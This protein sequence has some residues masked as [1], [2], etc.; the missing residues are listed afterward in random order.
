MFKSIGCGGLIGIANIVPGISG[1][2]LAVITNQYQRIIKNIDAITMIQLKNVEWGYL[3]C[4]A[5]G[6]IG[7][8]Y[9]F[10][11]PLDYALSHFNNYTLIMIIGLILGSLR[12]VKIGEEE[13]SY[14][15]RYANGWFLLG[16]ILI[17]GMGWLPA[18][19]GGDPTRAL[20][21]MISGA[22]AVMAMVIPGVSGSMM[23]IILGTY[24]HI[25]SLIK[26][27]NVVAFLP[28]ALGGLIGGGIAVKMIQKVIQSNHAAFESFILGG[29]LGSVFFVGNQINLTGANPLVICFS[30]MVS[31][32]ISW[33]LTH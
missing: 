22:V 33:K 32:G 1:A 4:I 12:G 5:F 26:T 9:L 20:T 30:L 23:L 10:S 6:A 21:L 15:Q 31:I 19:E 18:L 29:I 11:W 3:A 7:G 17:I 16:L 8:I 13:R 24:G 2:T 27:A 28:C 25:V 14:K